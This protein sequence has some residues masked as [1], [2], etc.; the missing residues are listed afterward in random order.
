[1]IRTVN[2]CLHMGCGEPLQAGFRRLV[3]PNICAPEEKT[4]APPL[5]RANNDPR[6]G[7]ST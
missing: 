5:R 3:K 7:R 1:M 4:A 2:R 6:K